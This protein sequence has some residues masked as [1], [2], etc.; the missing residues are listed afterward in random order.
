MAK[1]KK[2]T[3]IQRSDKIMD[4]AIYEFATRG[5]ANA[6]LSNIAERAGVS[7]GLVSARFGSKEELLC[8]SLF[9]ITDIFDKAEYMTGD[10]FD[11]LSCV[12][13]RIREYAANSSIEFDYCFN[14]LTGKD[15]PECV[16]KILWDYFTTDTAI[17]LLGDAMQQGIISKD[18]PYSFI[19]NVMVL[20]LQV[21]DNDRRF[22][23]D[24]RTNEEIFNIIIIN[25][26]SRYRINE[27][28]SN[29]D[30]TDK[31]LQIYE[32]FI[33]LLN[34]RF[35]SAQYYN[36]DTDEQEVVRVNAKID[37][38]TYK[39]NGFR[40]GFS[41]YIENYVAKD[42]TKRLLD[43]IDPKSLKKALKEKD[44]ISTRYTQIINGNEQYIMVQIS[45]GLD[46]SH[47]IAIFTNVTDSVLEQEAL[48]NRLQ[49]QEDKN[50]ELLR[51]EAAYQRAI[52]AEA[53]SYW[54]INLTKNRVIGKVNESENNSPTDLKKYIEKAMSDYAAGNKIWAAELVDR[55]Y[56]AEFRKKMSPEY[57]I[58]QFHKGNRIPE[59]I[60]KEKLNG[61]D[62]IYRHYVAYLSEDEK[63]GDI[64]A[65]MVA[66]DVTEEVL[67]EQENEAKEK[68]IHGLIETLYQV[69]DVEKAIE[70]MLAIVCNYHRAD[71][72][73]VFEFNKERTEALYRYEWCKRGIKSS[74]PNIEKIPFEYLSTWFLI[75]ENEGELRIDNIHK[76]L[77]K[78]TALYKS[79]CAEGVDSVL[80]A[81]IIMEGVIVGYIGLDN[82]KSRMD[83]TIV[84]K[85]SAALSYSEILR[86]KQ[87]D[88]E[89]IVSDHIY[90]SFKSVYYVDFITDYIA[91][92]TADEKKKEEFCRNKSYTEFMK[93][94][95]QEYI[96]ENS[97]ARCKVMLAPEYIMEQ[98]KNRDMV[99]V[100]YVSEK[101]KKRKNIAL[102]FIKANDAGTAAV[103]CEIDNTDAVIR[104]REVANRL[105]EARKA[106]EA[107]N[108]AKSRFLFNMSHDI[109]TP[110]NAIIGFTNLAEQSI[111]NK[112]LVIEYL[113]KVRNANS[114]LKTLVDDVLDMAR[115]EAG[116]FQI[117]DTVCDV[118]ATTEE[119]CKLMIADAKKKNITFT[120]EV[121]HLKHP[122]VWADIHRVKQI[123]IN[124]ISNAIKYTYEGGRVKYTVTEEDIDREGY[125]RFVL[126]VVD[127][128]IGMSKE[129]LERI[130][131]QF[132]RANSSTVSGV[133]GTGLGMAIVKRIV[134]MM[135]GNIRID[136]EEGKGT[137]VA[138]TL[139][140]KI[141]DIT[142]E[143]YVKEKE[144]ETSPEF[145]AGK[146]VLLVEDNHLN[147][148]IMQHIL[149]KFEMKVTTVQ[150]G[151]EA[152]EAVKKARVGEYDLILM[153][154]QM[155]VMNGYE[156]T[157]KI[158]AMKDKGAPI[159]I[160]AMTAN[161]FEEDKRAALDAG[162][163]GH[164]AKPINV[165]ELA[166][167]MH[168]ALDDRKA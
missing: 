70:R 103:I 110:M 47:A 140:A 161:A 21:F 22:G 157:K 44:T 135:G 69:E 86:R 3:K 87:N 165:K 17:T 27:E 138:I 35:I 11:R 85:T 131:N 143:E 60:A 52:L 88:E 45:R 145:F 153:D 25:N 102:R 16:D 144:Q 36:I 89:H 20:A 77:D 152:V 42:D 62:W 43:M 81:P 139:D 122:N 96:P 55:E 49:T 162:M 91:V 59:M 9:V 40:E 163:N 65:M 149:K 119:I 30:V 117:E 141:A 160:I 148:E 28:G 33:K 14:V 132:E 24:F 154:I 51:D 155:P 118:K 156:A 37:G 133:Q 12:I 54:K 82:P 164:V 97:C 10:V 84:L 120:Y 32:D 104:E 101:N 31:R 74:K 99:V 128:G 8:A 13:D 168:K 125:T 5:Y 92:H 63:T 142:P 29:F 72:A 126:K 159:P 93:R 129:F 76:A 108:E 150:D 166:K 112:E 167:T 73:Y 23:H 95:G 106:A 15:I 71:R 105:D 158:R 90:Q 124:V 1:E 50:A 136:S 113:D 26:K 146:K 137:R 41:N 130:Y 61:I 53:D 94:Y 7:Y 75:F 66:Y 19:R 6:K 57:L 115:I 46:E 98:F 18:D 111:D 78:R 48:E 127:N 39:K 121:R 4:A 56:R 67:A 38:I 79:L 68:G 58:E 2:L 107:A 34:K 80:A 83:E 134:D 116:R 64:Y 109:R 123:V 147:I 151:T 100:D 114:Y